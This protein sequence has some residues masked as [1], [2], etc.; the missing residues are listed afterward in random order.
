MLKQDWN[1][2]FYRPLNHVLRGLQIEET[3]LRSVDFGPPVGSVPIVAMMNAEGDFSRLTQG[4]FQPQTSFFVFQ[5]TRRPQSLNGYYPLVKTLDETGQ[6]AFYELAQKT[7]LN[8]GFDL[9]LSDNKGDDVAN[10]HPAIAFFVAGHLAE[11]F[12]YR[13]DILERLLAAKPGFW[14]Y[15]SPEMFKNDGGVGGGCFNGSKACIQLVLSRL[16]EGFNNPTPGA[17]PF[18]HEFGHMLDF[19]DAGRGVI[20]D[21]SSGFLPGM[22]QSDGAIYKPAAREL[23]LKG[24]RLELERYNR[25]VDG[26]PPDDPLPIGHPYVFQ[27]NTEF[28]AGYLE[29]FFRNPNYFAT[30]NLDLYQSF[31]LT[32]GQDPRKAWTQDFPFYVEQ[33]RGYYHSGKRP[34]KSGMTLPDR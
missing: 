9:R 6:K 25:L 1:E 12:F 27:N 24:K 20:E 19:L 5:L 22:R 11:V 4:S 15:T 17:A 23:F 21:K 32:F 10:R 33:N 29:M 3:S 7:L 34:N 26:A 18:L 28:I 30:Q 31:M 16:F 13:Q 14:L 8:P 2:V